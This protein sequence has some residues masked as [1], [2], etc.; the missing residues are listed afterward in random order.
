MIR[1]YLSD[2]INDSKTKGEWRFHSDNKIAEHKT[3]G[4]WKIHLANSTCTNKRR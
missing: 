4:E 2:I 1:P 3:Q